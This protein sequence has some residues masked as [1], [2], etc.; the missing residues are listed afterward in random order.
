MRI[1][2]VS[3][4][5]PPDTPFGGVAT[6]TQTAARG[7]ARRGHEVTVVTVTREAQDKRVMDEGVCVWRFSEPNY[8]TTLKEDLKR[9]WQ[10]WKAVKKLQP[11]IVH[12][13]EYGAEG[14]L[15]GL[16]GRQHYK[17]VT[18]LISPAT[19][20]KVRHEQNFQLRQAVLSFM[21]RRQVLSSHAVCSP[22]YRW[23]R[24]VE[25]DA[26]LKPGSVRKVIQGMNLEEMRHFRETEPTIKIDEPYL[27]YYGRVE[28]RKGVGYLAQAL[29]AVW[30]Q[31][32]NL[33][34]LF[35]GLQA[36]YKLEGI[37]SRQYIEQQAGKYAENL[38]FIDHL[39][40]EEVLPLVARAQLAV[41]PS[42]WEPYAYTS[43]EAIALGVP[44]VAT[45]D[46]GGMAEII[47]GVDEEGVDPDTVPAG[48]LVPRRSAKALSGAILEALNDEEVLAQVKAKTL[49]R[50]RQFDAT[51]MAEQ[52]ENLYLELLE[53]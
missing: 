43:M 7:L 23:G 29:P 13:V 1:C 35:V 41:L 4:D 40:R 9:N 2:F 26:K 53:Q 34:V 6:L 52:L 14:F 31:F 17:R 20:T 28:E 47:A 15:V 30:E 50:A 16:L 44:V 33:K 24:K 51:Q 39:P 22:S 42:L 27:I 21:A 49:L 3:T 11:Q 10:V 45:G 32:P 18:F 25:Q 38:V 37:P 48:W 36:A 8:R 12:L 5:Y 19:L 46:S